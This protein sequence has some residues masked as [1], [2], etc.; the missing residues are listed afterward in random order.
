M[1][2]I[3]GMFMSILDTSI[4]N[5]AIPSIQNEFGGTTDDVQW[6]VTGYTL[7]LG[8][9][10]PTTAWLSDRFGLTRVYNL[11]LLAF[12][13]GS[14]LCGLAWNLNSLVLFR[15][16]QAVPGGILPVITLSILYRIVPRDR[17]G[18]AMGLYGLGIVG[19][20]AV[21]P[22]LG[23]YLV[24]YVDWRQIF[25]INVPIGI[26][27][28]VASVLVLQQ[29]PKVAGRRFDVLGFLT[30]GGGLFALLLAASE[31][32]SWGWDSYLILGLFTYGVLS[33]ALFVVIELE[34]DDPLLDLRVF[35]Y[36]AF[37]HSLL[38]ISS[39][40]VVLF[41][42]VFYVPQF[43]QR[44]QGL[45]AFDTGLILLPPALVMG[46]LM[47][48][49]GQ[50]YDRIGPRWPAAIGLTIAAV[51]NYLLH[52]INLDTSR[53]HI[54][55]LLMLQYAGLGI[56]MMPIFSSGLA[57]IPT[58]HANAASACNNVVQRTSG[59]FGVAVCTAIL[60]TQQAQLMAGRAALMPANAPLANLGPTAPPGAD[61]YATYQQAELRAF[62]GAIDNLFLIFA[63]LCALTALGALLMRS[64]RA[65][66]AAIGPVPP[67]SG[68]PS[69]NGRPAPE[70][71]L[72]PSSATV[73]TRPPRSRAGAPGGRP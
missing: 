2:L 50:I 65:P 14:A 61:L 72:M 47:P 39:L 64:G 56:G 17:L 66:A 62:V 12:A 10:V 41:A 33:L 6:V 55:L 53:E 24:E 45:G 69:T 52:T 25:Y 23:G 71:I 59:A 11:A 36:G 19:A 34:V 15:I 28:A 9:V 29:F 38:L 31:G 40:S 18:A 1:V 26:L 4:V 32:S 27:G 68:S 51:G 49:S 3:A 22:T 58:A 21:G 63:A 43:L 54:M 20:P 73:A 57:V 44:G 5:V 37:T 35:R 67:A 60:T 30:V 13:A 46:V 48:V 16:L 70:R 7:T 42:V 8:V